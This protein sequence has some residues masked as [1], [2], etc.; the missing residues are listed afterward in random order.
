MT[1]NQFNEVVENISTYA[2]RAVEY[3][4]YIPS[5]DK[6]FTS[7]G[8]LQSVNTGAL[9]EELV[10]R[11]GSIQDSIHYK[12]VELLKLKRELTFKEKLAAEYLELK[13]KFDGN[14]FI[15]K[16]PTAIE[17]CANFTTAALRS[18]INAVKSA[19]QE[20]EKREKIM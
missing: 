4:S 17:L 18:K 10:I 11:H 5:V 12:N 13:V 8:I 16:Y 2:G 20:K 6:Y 9:K 1:R 14:N 15:G 3:Q 19:L 7:V